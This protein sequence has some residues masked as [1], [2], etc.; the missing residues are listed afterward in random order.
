MFEEIKNYT[1]SE[2]IEKLI[3][4]IGT[5]RHMYK[6]DFVKST[7]KNFNDMIENRIEF[8][9]ELKREMLLRMKSY[10]AS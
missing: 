3:S 9:A 7:A 1:N 4:Q 8:I 2:L 6:N 5:T 10:K